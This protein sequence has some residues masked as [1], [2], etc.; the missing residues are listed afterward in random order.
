MD[1][2]M[3]IRDEL[4]EMWSKLDTLQ[5]YAYYHYKDDLNKADKLSTQLF[6]IKELITKITDNLAEEI[7]S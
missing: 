7:E 1:Y 2:L 5:G 6:E 4:V 3:N